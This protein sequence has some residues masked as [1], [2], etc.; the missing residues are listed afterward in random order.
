MARIIDLGIAGP[1]DPIYTE[2]IRIISIRKP[3]PVT[4]ADSKTKPTDKTSTPGQVPNKTEPRKD[5]HP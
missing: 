2:G 1:D 4:Q 5:H 3:D